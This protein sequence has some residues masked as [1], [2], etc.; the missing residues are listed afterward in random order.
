MDGPKGLVAVEKGTFAIY[1]NA[2][3]RRV[4]PDV[5][6]RI[7]DLVH[8]DD[9]YLSTCLEDADKHAAKIIEKG[10]KTV[11]VGGGDGTVCQMINALYRAARKAGR[12]E[13]LPTLGALALG[14]GNALSRLVSSGSAIQDLKA[15]LS[16]PS[17]DTMTIPLV[18]SE[19]Y[20]FPFG[21]AGLDGE[22]L[23]DYEALKQRVGDGL[24]KPVFRNVAGYF[25]AF[26]VRTGPRAV[27]S[28]ARGRK[29]R[30]RITNVGEQ[31]FEAA[32]GGE[33]HRAFQPGEVIYDGEASTV[34]AG[35][36]PLIGYGA[37]V[38]PFAD[39][40]P[41]CFALRV[42]TIGLLRAL[43]SI[44]ELWRGTYRGEGVRDYYAQAVRID[45]SEPVPFQAG[46]DMLGRRGSLTFR[47][48]PNAVRL[49]RFF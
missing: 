46:G 43:I 25:F 37:K 22:I 36:I 24:L 31:A 4:S 12:A 19:G 16:N 21:G 18:E 2:N 39:R 9:I 8:P 20:L 1:L 35:T 49:L 26:L 13:G 41:G 10:Y 23:E 48:V 28:T 3:A 6:A 29:R 5:V 32:E 45:F 17:T 11:F 42:A 7:E 34:L 44:P 38:L 14:T 30:V 27:Y 47:L 33:R 40:E 15:Y